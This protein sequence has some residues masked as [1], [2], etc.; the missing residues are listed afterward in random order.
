[1][2]DVE[3]KKG[4]LHNAY[5]RPKCQLD[6]WTIGQFDICRFPAVNDCHSSFLFTLLYVIHKSSSFPD[7]SHQRSQGKQ[8]HVDRDSAPC[9]FLGSFLQEGLV[10]HLAVNASKLLD[11]QCAVTICVSHAVEHIPHFVFNRCRCSLRLKCSGLL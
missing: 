3:I 8:N 10:C 1:M 7:H 2:E 9:T 11:L 5:G 4:F 6:D